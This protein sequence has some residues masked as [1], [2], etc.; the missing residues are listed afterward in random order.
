MNREDKKFHEMFEKEFE[1]FKEDYGYEE[2]GG[3][4][5]RSN[6]CRLS[7]LDVSDIM[8][9]ARYFAEWGRKHL[10]Q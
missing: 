1:K 6:G 7:A 2:F 10:K 8:K 3:V 9:I 4:I 5:Y